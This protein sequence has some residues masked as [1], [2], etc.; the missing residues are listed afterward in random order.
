MLVLWAGGRLLLQSTHILME[1]TPAGIDP[2]VVL[3]AIRSVPDVA[4]VHHLHLWNLASDVAA[5]SAH[6][7]VAGRPTLG[8]AQRVAEQVKAELANRFGLINVTIELEDADS[9]DHILDGDEP[10]QIPPS[11]EPSRP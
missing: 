10:G 6:V 5:C 3:A 2:A 11:K 7:V 1:G 9:L 8:E 4:D